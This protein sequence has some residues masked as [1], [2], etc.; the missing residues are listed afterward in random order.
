[1]FKPQ[2]IVFDEVE[3]NRTL[4]SANLQLRHFNKILEKVKE[5]IELPTNSTGLNVLL[6]Y[7]LEYVQNAI[8]E[9]YKKTIDIPI[10][11]SKLLDLLEIDLEPLRETINN[12]KVQYKHNL[13]KVDETSLKVVTNVDINSFKHYTTNQAQ[14]TKLKKINNLIETFISIA[15]KGYNN[16]KLHELARLLDNNVEFKNDTL[17]P[18]VHYIKK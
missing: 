1:M 10:S 8:S 16:Y 15:D 7:P 14:N 3:Y 12:S 17:I 4:H 9:K 6:N 2:L 18:T 11:T 13:L 5:L